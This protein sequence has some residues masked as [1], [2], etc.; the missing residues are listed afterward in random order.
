[1]SLVTAFFASFCVRKESVSSLLEA[2]DE[3]HIWNNFYSIA[4]ETSL[5]VLHSIYEYSTRY[6]LWLTCV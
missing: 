2:D 3:Q 5:F 1:M 4:L 6:T